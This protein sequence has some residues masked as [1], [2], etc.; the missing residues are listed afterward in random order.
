MEPSSWWSRAGTWIRNVGR[1]GNS[2]GVSTRDLLPPDAD[3]S[4]PPQERRSRRQ[5]REAAL[6][7]LENG[8]QQVAN[9]VQS[10]HGHLQAQDRRSAEISG[11]LER[12]AETTQQISSVAEAQTQRLGDIASQLEA[13]NDRARRWEQALMEY[14]RVAETQREA[15]LSINRHLEASQAG[16]VR[17]AETMEGLR[18]AVASWG[19]SSAASADTLQQW[20]EA[21][22]RRDDD[23]RELVAAQDR[24]LTWLYIV[25]LAF[26]VTAVALAV[27]TL[28]R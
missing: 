14:P 28:V 20:K 13:A 19:E 10:I 1:G 8:Y 17:L 7:Q 27:F 23:F 26:A 2:D 9:L 3:G 12:L 18:G 15:L 25:T 6:E 11:A 5:Q 24:R 16:D 4:R 21:A 22:C